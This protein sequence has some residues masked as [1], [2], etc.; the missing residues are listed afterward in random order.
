MNV[1][2]NT[3]HILFGTRSTIIGNESSQLK[4]QNSH[5]DRAV[6]CVLPFSPT[7]HITKIQKP[8]NQ[9]FPPI[10]LCPRP[11]PAAENAQPISQL[12]SQLAS[13]LWFSR[14]LLHPQTGPVPVLVPVPGQSGMRGDEYPTLIIPSM[15]LSIRL[16]S[17]FFRGLCTQLLVRQGSGGFDVVRWD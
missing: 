13:Y 2:V 4:R 14:F 6:P 7:I 3:V 8:I 12:A 10:Y 11:R 16:L 9:T 17:D 1:A 5:H 15:D